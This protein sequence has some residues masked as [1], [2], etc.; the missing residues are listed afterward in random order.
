MIWESW[1]W[2]Q[3]LL[4]DAKKLDGFFLGED[5]EQANVD[6]ERAIFQAGFTIR[7]LL[8]AKK[9]TDRTALS[10]VKCRKLALLDPARIPDRMTRHW[11]SEFYDVAN[12]QS[13]TVK[14]SFLTNQLVHSFVFAPTTRCETDFHAEGFFLNS[15]YDRS[16]CLY[17]YELAE[18]VR[19]MRLVGNDEVDRIDY[20]RDDNGEW[21]S[22]NYG[23]DEPEAKQS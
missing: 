23:P 15:D 12:R 5:D 7:K 20:K 18:L 17:E 10:D 2:K 16:K 3:A 21:I 4:R 14:L 9:L 1:P 19:I 22:R 6:Y 11:P 8:E 13:A